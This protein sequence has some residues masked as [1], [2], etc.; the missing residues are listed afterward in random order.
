[1]ARPEKQN[2]KFA[3]VPG[4]ASCGLMQTENMGLGI[5]SWTIMLIVYDFAGFGAFAGLSITREQI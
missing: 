2:Q 3:I 4:M 1:L 5:V